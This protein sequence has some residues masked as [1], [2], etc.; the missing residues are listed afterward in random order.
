[1]ISYPDGMDETARA[2]PLP[3]QTGPR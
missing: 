1:M 3:P 2:A